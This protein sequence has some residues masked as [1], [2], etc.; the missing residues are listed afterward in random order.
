MNDVLSELTINAVIRI[1]SKKCSL[2]VE[3]ANEKSEST[4]DIKR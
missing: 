1:V 4:K 2:L 3:G